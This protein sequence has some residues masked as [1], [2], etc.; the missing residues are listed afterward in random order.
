LGAKNI[1]P[2]FSQICPE[3]IYA[4]HFL[5]TNFFAVAVGR[6]YFSLPCC[7]IFENRKFGTSNLFFNS[8]TEENYPIGCAETLYEA[9]HLAQYSEHLLHLSEAW[10]L[11]RQFLF[12]LHGQRKYP[13]VVRSADHGPVIML[14]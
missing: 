12:I 4:T 11:D 10:C 5:T 14:A 13:E 6:F 2:E 7:H 1:L 3:N 8:P 9:M